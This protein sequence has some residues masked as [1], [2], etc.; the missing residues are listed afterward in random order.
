MFDFPVFG[1]PTNTLTRFG[2][3]S[4]ALMDLKF[5]ILNVFIIQSAIVRA[6]FN[7]LEDTSNLCDFVAI[8]FQLLTAERWTSNCKTITFTA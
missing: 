6:W 1:L 3:T 4:S 2:F 5:S 8:F 7:S